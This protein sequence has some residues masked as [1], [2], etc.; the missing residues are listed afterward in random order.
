MI[1][2]NMGRSQCFVLKVEA[3]APFFGNLFE[4]NRARKSNTPGISLAS[5]KLRPLTLV[6]NFLGAAQMNKPT[7][8]VLSIVS[9]LVSSSSAFAGSLADRCVVQMNQSFSGQN[10]YD[11]RAWR[12][13]ACSQVSQNTQNELKNTS[14]YFEFA[15]LVPIAFMTNTPSYKSMHAEAISSCKHLE[16]EL[17][18]IDSQISKKGCEKVD[19]QSVAALSESLERRINTCDIYSWPG[20]NLEDFNAMVVKGVSDVLNARCAH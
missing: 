7:L 11:Q 20:P 14:S 1:P 9:I 4:E 3:R 16:K 8:L 6:F 19:Q 2:F 15:F 12:Y 10:D 5:V 17:A 13:H 18:N